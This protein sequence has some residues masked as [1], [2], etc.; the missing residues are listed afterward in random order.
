MSLT[1][2]PILERFGAEVSG[3]DISRPLDEET[4]REIIDIQNKWGITVWRDTGLDDASHVA[5][6]RIFGEVILAPATRGKPRFAFPELFDASNLDAEGNII[7]DE[8]RRL[9]NRGNRL[10]HA[11]SSF[12]Q[13]RAAQSLLLCHEAPNGG[14]T[15]FA[16]TRSAYDDLPQEMKD[17]L[18]GL[19]A[20]HCYFWSRRKAGYPYT[21]EDV[22]RFPHSTHPVVHVHAG[23]GRKALFL[24]AHARDIVGMNRDEGRALIDELNA[25]TTKQDYI[26]PVEYRPGD[27]VI[28]DNLC[29]YH[30]AGDFDEA[31]HRR[32]M[33]RTTIRD[34]QA[35]GSGEGSVQAM[36]SQASMADAR[37]AGLAP[38]KK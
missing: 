13:E 12:V 27:M 30:R 21:E 35:P 9:T 17:R 36:F 6:S 28:W 4:Q 3:V 14:P 23:S 32:D 11:D 37:I 24:G 19:E 7:D 18:E 15:W 34:P 26:F 20:R 2:K 1:V 38:L 25:W 22:D 31:L 10:W 5:F 8:H 16:D 33:R 29:S